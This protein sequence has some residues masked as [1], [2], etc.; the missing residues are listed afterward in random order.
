MPRSAAGSTG[1]RRTWTSNMRSNHRT[2]RRKPAP[3][4]V[5]TSIGGGVSHGGRYDRSVI[6][7]PVPSEHLARVACARPTGWGVMGLELQGAVVAV[8]GAAGGIGAAVAAGFG[9][10]GAE[11]V[12]TD[13]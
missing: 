5:S 11:V 12:R 7:W 10:S 6:R 8:T 9:A 2:A 1:S 4:A 3:A 13:L